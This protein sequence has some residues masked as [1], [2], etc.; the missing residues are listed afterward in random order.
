MIQMKDLCK[1]EGSSMKILSKDKVERVLDK[2]AESAEVFVP[3]SRANSSGFY[4][5]KTRNPEKEQLM[6]ETLNVYLSPKN[7]GFPQT[8]KMYSIIQSGTEAQIKETFEDSSPRIIFGLRACDARA[9]RCLDDVFLTRGDEDSF[10]KARRDNM[11]L[12]GQACY[13]PGPNCFCQAM[14]VDPLEPEVDIVIR[15]CGDKGYIWETKTPKG[16]ELTTSISNLLEEKELKAPEAKAFQTQVDYEGVAEKLKGMFEHPIW[17]DLSSNCQNCGICTYVCP[18]C[19]CFDIQVKS[20]GEE[21]YRF[22]CWDSCM[23]GEYTAEAGGG[24][25]RPTTKERFRNR[26]L[27]KLEF[28][29]ER[30]GYPLCTGCGRCI[31]ACPTGIN[32]VNIINE[33]KEAS[34]DV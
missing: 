26:F 21:G 30:Y 8:E 24:N 23:Y 14:G 11:V 12:I 2:L 20:W 4:S 27:H 18:S 3:L 13:E 1:K 29:S 33:V 15:D 31:V 28:F 19:H 5:W 6:L 7:V 32:I 17:E 9:I 34:V 22:R 25:P 10:Y 16:E